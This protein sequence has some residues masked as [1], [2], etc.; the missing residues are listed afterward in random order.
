VFPTEKVEQNAI[1]FFNC[2]GFY[3]RTD[4][5]SLSYNI[6]QSTKVPIATT[7]AQEMKCRVCGHSLNAFSEPMVDTRFGIPDAFAI[8]ACSECG[9]TQLSPQP[10]PD[11][12]RSLY[13]R[14]Y[15]FRGASTESAYTGFRGK[16]FASRLYKLWLLMDGDISF[17]RKRGQGRLL[18]IGCNEGR[19]LTIYR[20]N[21]FDAEGLEWNG[22]AAAAAR[23]R[24]FVVH[25]ATVEGLNA[26]GAFDVAVLSN[27]LE[28]ALDPLDMLRQIKRV[29]RPGGQLWISCPNASSW[30]RR[31]FGRYWIN[32]HVPFHLFQFDRQNLRTLLQQS[33]FEVITIKNA[34]PALWVAQTIISVFA[35]KRGVPTRALRRPLLVGGLILLIRLL[36]FPFL[37]LAN[38]LGQGDCL[39]VTAIAR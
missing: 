18:D 34:T 21:G 3:S 6:D 35:F 4:L 19:S 23:R 28:H 22:V 24:G 29:L 38:R 5:G 2:V 36:T 26:P 15:N 25:E 9:L 1:F 16:F 13:E 14:Y 31:L 33:G 20:S 12:L 32:W 10:D 39:V 27:V 17:H 30:L 7:I 11:N 8:G 37:W